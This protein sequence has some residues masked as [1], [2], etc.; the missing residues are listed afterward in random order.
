MVIKEKCDG[1]KGGR[2]EREGEGERWGR[3]REREQKSYLKFP[4]SPTTIR[5]V[6]FS[7]TAVANSEKC[8]GIAA[9]Q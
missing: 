1:G 8:S 3:G 6:Q 4:L 9:Q 2:G 7:F 5:N